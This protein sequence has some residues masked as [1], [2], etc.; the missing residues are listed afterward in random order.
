M[1]EI[2]EQDF[3]YIPQTLYDRAKELGLDLRRFRPV[4][5]IP[6]KAKE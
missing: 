2:E 1:L 3:I 4:P 5:L 6:I